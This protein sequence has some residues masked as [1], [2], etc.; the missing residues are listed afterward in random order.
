MTDRGWARGEGGGGEEVRVLRGDRGR[1]AQAHSCADEWVS[2]NLHLES[3]LRNESRAE[4]R[5]RREM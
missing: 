5:L 4:Q 3:E 2:L 1:K